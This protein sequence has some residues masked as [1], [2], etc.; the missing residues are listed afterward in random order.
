MMQ[1]ILD[2]KDA[3][4]ELAVTKYHVILQKAMREARIQVRAECD[5]WEQHILIDP[6]TPDPLE[7]RLGIKLP[8]IRVHD[9]D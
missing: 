1:H 3:E 2:I 7:V 9:P 5:Q 4:F 6:N 8:A